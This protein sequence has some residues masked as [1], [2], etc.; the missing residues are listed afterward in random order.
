MAA[1]EKLTVTGMLAQLPDALR[2]TAR[3]RAENPDA[4]LEELRVLHDPPITKSGLNHRLRKL[5]DA[6]D[7]L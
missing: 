6:A 2:L 3:L 7:K 5:L 4:T 1:I